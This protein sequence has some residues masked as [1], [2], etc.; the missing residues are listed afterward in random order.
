MKAIIVEILP[1]S[2]N[3]QKT[4]YN[5]TTSNNPR[6]SY[7]LFLF[8]LFLTLI[9]LSL[10]ND[11][12][13]PFVRNVVEEKQ[14]SCDVF[15]GKWVYQNDSSFEPYYTNSTCREIYDQLNC[16]KFGRP[17]S[18]FLRWKW[19]P[20]GCELARFD[21]GLFLENMRNKAMAFV[22]DSVGRNQM[23][24]LICLLSSVTYPVDQSENYTTDIINN[25]RWYYTEYN[26]TLAMMWAP[27][28]V[29]VRDEASTT[30][31]RSFGNIMM[32]LDLDRPSESW[33]TQIKDFDYVIVSAGQWFFRPLI[34]Y[35]DDV[36]VSCHL[37]QLDNVTTENTFYGYKMAFRMTFKAILGLENYKGVTFLRTF[38]PSHFENGEWDK[39]GNCPRTKPYADDEASLEGYIFEMY[40]SQ[41]REFRAA[42]E[43]AKDKGLEFRLLDTT[44]AMIMRPDGHPNHYGHSPTAKKSVADCVHWCLPGPIDTWNEFLQEMIINKKMVRVP[45]TQMMQ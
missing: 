1:N 42:E 43:I 31:Q 19:Q 6:T 8:L 41:M 29:K 17:D 9:P 20:D 15:A 27:Y 37:C 4:A 12:R 3:K 18:D 25:R 2:I 7:L 16:M 38:S 40:M 34:F 33:A 21:A 26:F 44:R 23:Q 35:M 10:I 32:Q 30:G 14:P 11:L 45:Y 39:G 5:T 36:P 22:G 13:L 24:S 28:L